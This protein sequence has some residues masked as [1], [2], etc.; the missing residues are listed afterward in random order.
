MPANPYRVLYFNPSLPV[1]KFS[2]MAASYHNDRELEILKKCAQLSGHVVV[3]SADLHWYQRKKHKSSSF[4]IGKHVYYFLPS[5]VA[6]DKTKGEST[7]GE[8]EV[9]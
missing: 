2:K 6:Q 7:D 8:K 5:D 4:R 1:V 3:P 9:P